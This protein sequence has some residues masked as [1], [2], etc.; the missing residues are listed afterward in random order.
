MRSR[1]GDPDLPRSRDDRPCFLITIDTE[2]DNA[3]ARPREIATENARHLPRFQELCEAFGLR[4]TYLTNHEMAVSPVFQEFGKDVLRR[5]TGEI[6]MHLH[7]WDSPPAHALTA[8]DLEQHP[9]LIE[10]PEEVMRRKVAFMTD[11]LERTFEV[12]MVSHRAGRWGFDERYARILLEHGY[13]VDCSVTPHISWRHHEGD[14]R[15]AGSDYTAYPEEAYFVDLNDLARPG[16]SDLL[17]VPMTIWLDR[18]FV[19]RVV[20]PRFGEGTLARRAL[21]RF[22]PARTWLR[23]K[24]RN[25]SRMVGVLKAVCRE[26]RRYAEFM[27]HS[28][29]LMPGG[30]PAFP[31]PEAVERLYD[32]LG[33]LFAMAARHFRG[34][35][36][37]EFRQLLRR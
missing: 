5:G 4:P 27:V 30:S 23:P 24:G 25:L 31:T 16:D 15:P 13:R 34:A 14:L 29:E 21:E 36:L 10:Y 9:Y 8:D 19:A 28:S 1:G 7:A 6:G 32:E 33:R 20:K 11:L 12:K 2:G 22:F 26:G 37:S 35:T 3:W 18:G 17:E